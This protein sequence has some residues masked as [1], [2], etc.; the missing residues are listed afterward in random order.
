MKKYC[1][2]RMELEHISPYLSIRFEENVDKE[3]M[4]TWLNSLDCVAH[5]NVN[6]DDTLK[7]KA[8][9]YPMKNRSLQEVAEI[10]DACLTKILQ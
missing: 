2:E 7:V 6:E 4:R 5:C 8:L 3:L 9:V 10:V 1:I